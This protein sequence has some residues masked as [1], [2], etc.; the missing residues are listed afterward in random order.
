MELYFINLGQIFYLLHI[1]TDSQ[2]QKRFKNALKD[3][4]KA[5]VVQA[6]FNTFDRNSD[7]QLS[8]DEIREVEVMA[9]RSEVSCTS[10]LRASAK[11]V[12]AAVD[13]PF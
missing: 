4:S 13:Q 2:E 1:I 5:E 12:A 6:A 10:A 9:R 8:V 3:R 11:T 7:K